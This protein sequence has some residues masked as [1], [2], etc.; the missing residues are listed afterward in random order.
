MSIFNTSGGIIMA[1]KQKNERGDKFNWQPGDVQI[2]SVDEWEKNQAK[3]RNAPVKPQP[4]K[5]K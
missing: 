3:K 5:K 2:M 1:T 4:K